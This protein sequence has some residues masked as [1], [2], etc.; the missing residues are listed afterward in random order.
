MAEFLQYDNKDLIDVRNYSEGDLSEI[1]VFLGDSD[2]YGE[3]VFTSRIEEEVSGLYEEAR[4]SAEELFEVQDNI[5]NMPDPSKIREEDTLLFHLGTI[6]ADLREEDHED[7][8]KAAE[9]LEHV[10]DYVLEGV[11]ESMPILQNSEAGTGI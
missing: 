10:T 8:E 4:M 11:S 6:S 9:Y 3:G 1:T 2:D 5:V 7:I